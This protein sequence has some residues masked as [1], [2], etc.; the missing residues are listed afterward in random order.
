MAIIATNQSTGDFEKCSTGLQQAVC[1][2]VH[3]IGFQVGQWQ[4]QEKIQHKVIVTWELAEK[5]KSGDPFAI[6][7]YYTLSLHEKSNL[8][9]DLEG[10][11]G[12]PFTEDELAGVDLEELRGVNCYL[13]ISATDKDKRKVVS[14]APLPKGVKPIKQVATEP[15]EKFNEWIARERAKA[16]NPAEATATPEGEKDLPF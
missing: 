5:M 4:G 16:V 14:V 8:R 7:K 6:S 9:K 15:S 12:K 1:V 10:W 2:F 3:D 13:N 11:R